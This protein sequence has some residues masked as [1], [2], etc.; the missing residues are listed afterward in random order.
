MRGIAVWLATSKF[1]PLIC[2]FILAISAQPASSCRS[3]WAQGAVLYSHLIFTGTPIHVH[4]ISKRDNGEVSDITFKVT[5]T[6]KG[7]R[8]REVTITHIGDGCS[9]LSYLDR[10]NP[11]AKASI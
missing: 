11:M 5:R 10:A 9:T 3:L 4:A 8:L 6:L 7:P 1:S 2:A